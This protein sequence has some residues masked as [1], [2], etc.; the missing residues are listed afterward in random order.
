MR[1]NDNASVILSY[2]ILHCSYVDFSGF[3]CCF[4]SFY[5]Y[6]SYL[7]LHVYQYTCSHILVLTSPYLGLPRVWLDCPYVLLYY[8]PECPAFRYVC[9]NKGAV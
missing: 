2:F 5:L 9:K 7:Y 6:F 3:F 8:L 4:S 1:F